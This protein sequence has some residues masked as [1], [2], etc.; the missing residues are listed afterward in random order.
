MEIPKGA[1]PDR[2]PR[3]LTVE[4][5]VVVA[6]AKAAKGLDALEKK[7]GRKPS[8][9]RETQRAATRKG[10]QYASSLVHIKNEVE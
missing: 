3:P 5:E 2:K 1:I 8:K 10:M 6:E 7:F 4:E 9:T